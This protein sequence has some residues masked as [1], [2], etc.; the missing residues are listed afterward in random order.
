MSMVSIKLP[1]LV[2]GCLLILNM[3]VAFAEFDRGQ[4]LYEDNCMQCHESWAHTRA[5]HKVQS[6]GELRNRVAGWSV[7]SGLEWTEEEVDDVVQ[8]LNHRFYQFT[9][10]L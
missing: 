1:G 4:A 10:Q 2:V 6:I 5:N 8:Y 9:E 3:P 7:H